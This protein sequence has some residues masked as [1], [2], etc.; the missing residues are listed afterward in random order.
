M[1]IRRI[2]KPRHLKRGGG[3]NFGNRCGEDSPGCVVC[4]AYAFKDREGRFPCSWEELREH[5]RQPEVTA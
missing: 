1:K 3:P 2:H 4:D 5:R